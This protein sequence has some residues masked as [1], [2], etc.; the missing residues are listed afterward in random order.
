MGMT[1]P[2]GLRRAAALSAV[3]ALSVLATGA[4]A[5]A[6]TPPAGTASTDMTAVDLTVDNLPSLTGPLAAQALDITTFAS[7]DSDPARNVFGAGS[8]FALADL[9]PLRFAGEER[10]RATA[11]SDGERDASVGTQSAGEQTGPLGVDINP[12]QI[13]AEA[14]TEQ[15]EALVSAA[16]GRVSTLLGELGIDLNLTGVRSAV[17]A[18]KA[19]A[20]QGLAVG[21]FGV[22]L[23]DLVPREVLEQLPLDVLVSLLGQIPLGALPDVEAV[24]DALKAAVATVEATVDA[25]V[26]AGEEVAADL[27]E[28]A[29]AQSDLADAESAEADAQAVL[30]AANAA[31]SQIE[32]DLATL[33]SVDDLTTL[34]LAA[35]DP[36]VV[37][38]L[39]NII[40]AYETECGLTDTLLTA[41][42][43]DTL[44]AC[45]GG[46]GGLLE[47]AQAD[48][49]AAQADL[50]AASAV[51]ATL[52]GVVDGLVASVTDLVAT[53]VAQAEQLVGNLQDL[54][55]ALTDLEANLA[56]VLDAL[57]DGEL[58]GVGAL[59]VG[60][61]ARAA[62]TPA[63][64]AATLVCSGFEASVLGTAISSP[65]CAE[66]LTSAS[67]VIAGAVSAL[68]GVLTTL[69]IAG[70]VV[71]DVE[72]EALTD[73]V[74]SV[75][76]DG[77]YVVAE[78]GMTILR[79][80]L[81]SVTIDPAEIVD[82]LLEQLAAEA[83]AT[84][85]G[86]LPEGTTLDGLGLTD[87]T[88]QIDG[89]SD[90][91]AVI[92]TL[93]GELDTLLT[94][95]GLGGLVESVATPGVRL[96]VDPVSSAE[97]R[98]GTAPD[99]PVPPAPTAPDSSDLPMT[100]GERPLLL[101]AALLLVTSSGLA[102]GRRWRTARTR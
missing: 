38:E 100:G 82:G 49:A 71:P 94:T 83:L 70:D 60:F 45:L 19:E 27:T 31:V 72:L 32:S 78:A 69:P 65:D 58:L 25:L 21:D 11:R 40:S 95:L 42:N 85:E 98:P 46:T 12:I 87:L 77:D 34:E 17:D 36:A 3:L 88:A 55:A 5:V 73:V 102:V 52:Q 50:D 28:L 61:L 43:I 59:E 18:T 14:A 92:G 51:V 101:L 66:P 74:R 99:A 63:D 97:F 64:S 90:E 30:D 13:R 35:L 15:A 93:Q 1:F 47:Q 96:V 41:E 26:A 8:P 4:G 84:V 2:R 75:K 44:I 22:A 76:Q 37:T 62:A 91:L 56:D 9:L 7:T 57:A 33:Q 89:L 29:S 79:L 6:A 16:A 48:A 10:G 24:V 23:G 86:A 81:P 68:Q 67:D 54:L 39:L 20:I 53:L 80:G